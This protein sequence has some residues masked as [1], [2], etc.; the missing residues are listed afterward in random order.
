[1][2]NGSTKMKECCVKC[3]ET[4][5]SKCPMDEGGSVDDEDENGAEYHVVVDYDYDD[6]DDDS[7]RLDQRERFSANARG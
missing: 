6:D 3:D 7:D 1:V 5:S 2:K 4:R